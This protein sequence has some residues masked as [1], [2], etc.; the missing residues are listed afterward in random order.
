MRTGVKRDGTLVAHE[1][2]ALF[3]SGAY[4]GYKPSQ[5]LDLNGATRLGGP[6][7]I[8]HYR[9]EAMLVYT[10]Q[11]P[12]GHMRSPGLVQSV[13][14][15]E[16]QIDCVARAIGMDPMEFRLKNVVRGSEQT[17]LGDSWV[18]PRAF[19]TLALAREAAE[20]VRPR[21]PGVGLGVALAEHPAGGGEGSVAFGWDGSRFIIRTATPDTG[22]GLHTIMAQVAAEE[23]D[24]AVDVVH[25]QTVDTDAFEFD[26]GIGGS[27][28]THVHGQAARQAAALLRDSLVERSGASGWTGGRPVGATGELAPHEVRHKYDGAGAPKITGFA[29]Q[30]AEVAVDGETGQVRVLAVVSAH[31]AGTVINPVYHQGQINGGVIQALGYALIEDLPIDD[32]KV[33]AQNFGDYKIPV[34]GDIPPLKTV[35]LPPAPGPAPYEAKAIGETPNAPL[36]A[37]IANAVHAA[38]G[39]RATSLPITA[40]KVLGLL[41]R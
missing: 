19:E 2:S 6:Y 30:V 21:P 1:A 25:V 5:T 31:D 40:E 35:L 10:N 11:V 36:A 17:A 4:G 29:A 23:L 16:S 22:T 8:P 32:G 38:A 3:D 26:G 13:F 33:L 18:D 12:C 41:E 7:R 15:I 24:V 39:V 9:A 20:W 37:S 28:S 34:A 14:A 27:R